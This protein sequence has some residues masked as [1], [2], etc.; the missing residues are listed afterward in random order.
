MKVVME[1][2]L[3]NEQE[4]LNDAQNGY[5]W[6]SAAK[7][8]DQALRNTIKYEPADFKGDINT[9]ENVRTKFNEILSNYNLRVY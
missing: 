4:E 5:K 2:N 8:F 9:L 1:F 7:E 3:P 6:A